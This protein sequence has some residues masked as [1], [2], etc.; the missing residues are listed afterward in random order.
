M[1]PEILEKISKL[2]AFEH[3]AGEEE[4][5]N[6]V[7]AAY[8]LMAKHGITREQVDQGTC[9]FVEETVHEGFPEEAPE[10]DPIFDVLTKFFNVRVLRQDALTPDGIYVPGALSHFLGTK[11][12]VEVAKRVML[13]LQAQFKLRWDVTKR[14]RH[15]DDVRSFAYGMRDGLVERLE[16]ERRESSLPSAD[17]MVMVKTDQ[18]LDDAV[19]AQGIDRQ[20]AEEIDLDLRTYEAGYL[21]G[22]DVDVSTELHRKVT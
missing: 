4:T 8:K 11:D 20:P 14:F 16:R 19:D 2:L 10:L 13:F 12:D 6:A 18:S 3:S 7:A 5:E 17:E 21:N 15:C 1:N 22:L 9:Q